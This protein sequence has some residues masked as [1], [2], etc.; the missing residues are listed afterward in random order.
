MARPRPDAC[1]RATRAVAALCAGAVL[2]AWAG[3][4]R[5]DRPQVSVAPVDGDRASL[6]L[7]QRMGQALA[8][9]LIASGADVAPPAVE[10]PYVLRGKLE[11]E[12][13]SYVFRLEMVDRKSGGVVAS[14]ED[15]CE[16]CTEAEAFETANTAASTLKAAVFKR[17][18]TAQAGGGPATSSVVTAAAPSAPTSTPA[19][20]VVVEAKAAPASGARHAFG[21]A[22]IVG[23]VA[24]AGVGA[25]LFGIDGSGTCDAVGEMRCPRQYDTRWGGIGLVGLGVALVGAGVVALLT[26]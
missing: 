10:A 2:T 3:A 23:G 26:R 24:S 13:R 12:G 8:E 17:G 9:G 14:R 11:V 25:Y 1:F 4:A 20:P 18:S 7:R 21:W 16:I 15:R 19:P 6:E 22:A 5:A